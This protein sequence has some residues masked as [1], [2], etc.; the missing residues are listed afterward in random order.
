MKIKGLCE[1]LMFD[2][3][4]HVYKISGVKWPSVTQLMKP[5]VMEI[6]KDVSE[7]ALRGAADKGT[8]VHEAFEI[9]ADYGYE[10]IPEEYAGYLEGLKKFYADFKVKPI[11]TEQR[12]YHKLYCYAGTA[13]LIAEINGETVL[14]DYKTTAQIQPVL[15]AV[16]LIAYRKAL[17][18]QGVKISYTA[19][20]HVSKDGN[21]KFIRQGNE[22]ESWDVF[23]GLFKMDRFIRKHA[24]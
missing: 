18:S 14:V 9:Y 5:L 21:Y 23:L 12:F 8:T 1:D 16:Q 15:T 22:L 17:E 11:A 13:D 19:I 4:E 10:D 3:K 6:Y 20:L 2:E 24:A 7:V